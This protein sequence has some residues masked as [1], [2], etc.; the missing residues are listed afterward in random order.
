MIKFIFIVFYI[1]LLLT[2]GLS[3]FELPW[4]LDNLSNIMYIWMALLIISTPFLF[5]ILNK[6]AGL[7]TLPAVILI[8]IQS[9]QLMSKPHSPENETG[10]YQ[11]I[12][13]NLSYYNEN[14]PQV[15]SEFNDIDPDFV[16]LFEFNDKKRDEFAL[17]ANGKHMYGYEEI[18]GFP[19]GIAVVSKL[20]IVFSHLHEFNGKSAKILE[21]K[22]FDKNL[23]HVIQIYLLHPPSPRNENNW[24]IRNQ[25]FVELQSLIKNS[26][27][28]SILIAGDMNVSP[29]SYYYPKFSGFSPCYQGQFKF[30]SWQ[31]KNTLPMS[32]ITSL[33]DHCFYNSGLNLKKYDHI[34][35]DGSDHQALV[36]QLQLMLK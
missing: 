29:W 24:R 3:F 9:Y 36:Y 21:L 26:A 5:L 6:H 7:S 1:L 20:P 2:Q 14:L 23:N 18:Q 34:N 22:L 19:A 10:F 28:K 15:F 8:L 35:I 12:Q 30:K 25:L 32:L 13:A 17:Y 33:I 16:F 4:W 31:Y 11:V 27:H